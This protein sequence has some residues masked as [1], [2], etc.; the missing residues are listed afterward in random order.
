V[1]GLAVALG[2]ITAATKL[3]AGWWAARRIG[4]GTRGRWRAGTALVARGEFSIV[5]A[6]LGTA[7]IASQLRPLAAAYVLFMVVLGPLTARAIEP[8]VDLVRARIRT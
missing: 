3:A 2:L 4:V 7:G 6:G 5:I 8:V 1:A